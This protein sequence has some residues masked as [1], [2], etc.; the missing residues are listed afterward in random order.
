MGCAAVYTADKGD[1]AFGWVAGWTVTE[2]PRSWLEV[3]KG[4]RTGRGA[5]GV[6]ICAGGN[7]VTANEIPQ[8]QRLEV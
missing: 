7:K 1:S 8:N 4:E 3:N 2:D 5:E 6:Y